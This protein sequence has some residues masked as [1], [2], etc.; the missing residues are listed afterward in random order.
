MQTHRQILAKAPGVALV[1]GLISRAQTGEGGLL[2]TSAL[3][4]HVV[5][6]Q[7]LICGVELHWRRE[8]KERHFMLDVYEQVE[9]REVSVLTKAGFEALEAGYALEGMPVHGPT[10]RRMIDLGVSVLTPHSFETLRLKFTRSADSP[11]LLV[12]AVPTKG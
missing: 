5:G 1:T 12:T 9:T 3:W 7:A 10:E 8:G 11:D 6:A 4:L 2:S